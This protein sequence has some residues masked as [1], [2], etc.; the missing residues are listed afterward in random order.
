MALVGCFPLAV[1]AQMSVVRVDGNKVYLDTSE[2]KPA[3]TLGSTFKVILSSETLTNPK[4]GKNLGEVYTYSKPG[5]ITEVQPLYCIGE[6]K[7]ISGINVGKSAVLENIQPAGAAVATPA[8]VA[9]SSRD[10]TTYKPVEQTIISITEA[11]VT[12]PQAHN[13]ITLSDKNEITVFSRAENETL[14]QEMSFKLPSGKKGLTLSAAAVKAGLAQIFVTAY[15]DGR[16]TINTLVLENKNGELE[17]TATLPFFVKELG[18]GDNKKIWGQRPFVLGN[19]PGNGREIVYNKNKF[20]AGTE[21]FDTRHNFLEG[22]NYFAVENAAHN[23]LIMTASN[24]TLRLLLANGKYAESKDLF[25]STPLRLQY[26]QEIIKF[27]PS[28]QVFGEPGNATLAAIENGTKLGLLSET[29]GQYQK[30]KLHFLDYEKGRLQ[31][32]DTVEMDGVLYDSAC[33]ASSIL[34][35]E[36]L[37]DGTSTVVEISKQP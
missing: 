22:I 24:G 34:T 2:Q 4:T 12:A 29:F 27:Y 6:L 7:D 20:S 17:N 18:C 1:L 15:V 3:P 30:G 21:Q 10:K 9:V 37:P 35:A 8:T 14:K 25:G 23:N 26:K 33:T 31:I 13:I 32:T 11:D 36:A 16:N 5:T 19:A 28:I